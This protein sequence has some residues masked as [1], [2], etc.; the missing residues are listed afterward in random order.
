[1]G[2]ESPL[3]SR[4]QESGPAITLEDAC[5]LFAHDKF[6][7]Y[8]KERLWKYNLKENPQDEELSEIVLLLQ[9]VR[10]LH[11]Q[12][13]E[14]AAG[15]TDFKPANLPFLSIVS[16]GKE[17]SKRALV[18][19]VIPF[20]SGHFI[21]IDEAFEKME[22]MV[23][24]IGLLKK[25]RGNFKNIYEFLKFLFSYLR[26]QIFLDGEDVE[27]LSYNAGEALKLLEGIKLRPSQ[28][29]LKKH[30]DRI[31]QK[32]KPDAVA[33]ESRLGWHS[34]ITRDVTS[35]Q[36]LLKADLAEGTREKD[37]TK[38]VQAAVRSDV[39]KEVLDD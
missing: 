26:R 37:Y 2:N 18:I 7:F 1:M 34:A 11:E 16:E 6:V 10:K 23:H 32:F 4:H 30:I 28:A 8:E 14:A 13:Y 22:K 31:R 27:P 5:E 9:L 24:L 36:D 19:E 39:Q 15:G 25:S 17:S 12:F 3:E 20:G 29:L 35:V 33:L 21:D 38:D